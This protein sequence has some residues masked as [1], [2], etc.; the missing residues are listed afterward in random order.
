MIVVGWRIPTVVLLVT[1]IKL[2]NDAINKVKCVGKDKVLRFL[3]KP[4]M[5]LIELD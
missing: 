4:C 5:V 2:M 3:C 1:S